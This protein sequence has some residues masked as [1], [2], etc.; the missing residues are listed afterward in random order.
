MVEDELSQDERQ[1]IPDG[2]RVS[3]EIHYG[4]SSLF[5][6]LKIN[7]GDVLYNC[8]SKLQSSDVLGVNRISMEG[9]AVAE[10]GDETGVEGARQT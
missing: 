4:C 1:A 8:A 10:G 6:I 5:L 7:R 9:C 3:E 2:L